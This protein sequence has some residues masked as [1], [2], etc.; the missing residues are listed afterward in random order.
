MIFIVSRAG[1]RNLVEIVS[2]RTVN[3]LR[4]SQYEDGVRLHLSQKVYGAFNVCA[5]TILGIGWVFAEMRSEVNYDFII[6]GPGDVE[7][8]QNI[9]LRS[10]R[11]I[12]GCE[13]ISHLSA[14]ISAAAGD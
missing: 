3:I 2:V 12:F 1:L 5:K 14:E 8:A 7:R 4:R 11:K 9:E 10:S 13:E 6:A